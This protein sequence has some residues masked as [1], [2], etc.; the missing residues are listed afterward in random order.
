MRFIR[1]Q[2]KRRKIPFFPGWPTEQEIKKEVGN[3][4]SA[5]E[6]LQLN[7]ECEGKQ[8]IFPGGFHCYSSCLGKLD[9]TN[10]DIDEN[11]D[12]LVFKFRRF[13]DNYKMICSPECSVSHLT[14][15]NHEKVNWK[16]END[17]LNNIFE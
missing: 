2:I 1:L 12:S 8:I 17:L 10:L 14:I 16:L 5:S 7:E 3:I 13:N 11:S 6:V 9:T 15:S 4:L